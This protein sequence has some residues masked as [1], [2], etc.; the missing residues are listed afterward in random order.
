VRVELGRAVANAIPNAQFVEVAGQDSMMWLG[1][2]DAI[3]GEVEEFLT[4]SRR[5]V[6]C[7]ELAAILF[8]DIVGSTKRAAQLHH[9]QWQRLLSEHDD[10]VRHHLELNGGTVIKAIGDGFLA[11]FETPDQAVRAGELANQDTE[12]LG[13]ELRVGIHVGAVE[14]LPDDVRGIAVHIAARITELA[15]PRQV[16]VSQTVKDILV[17]S[18]LCFEA[19]SEQ[20][21]RGVPGRWPLYALGAEHAGEHSGRA[22]LRLLGSSPGT[23][24]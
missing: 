22:R 18:D 24:A 9:E 2:A 17:D 16:L 15:E 6:P 20:P 4:G 10:I 11:T 3:L 8:T 12:P 21:L 14:K 7:S 19:A 5:I 23:S 1:D 13:L